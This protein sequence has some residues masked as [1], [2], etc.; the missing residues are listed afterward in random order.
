M[1]DQDQKTLERVAQ[2]RRE[3]NELGFGPQGFSSRLCVLQRSPA[4]DASP[5][6]PW[7]AAF[8]NEPLIHWLSV[9]FRKG[10]GRKERWATRGLWIGLPLAIWAIVHVAI[11]Y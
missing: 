3:I 9:G 8:Y 7:V 1:N 6:R 5:K 10:A 2:L 4:G 11:T